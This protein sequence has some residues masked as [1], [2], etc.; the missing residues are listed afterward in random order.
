[1]TGKELWKRYSLEPAVTGV[2]GML[3]LE[4]RQF[5]Y[6]IARDEYRGEGEIMDVGAFLG[7]SAYALAAGLRDNPRSIDRQRRIH[8]CD[9]FTYGGYHTGYITGGSWKIGDDTLPIYRKHL[10]P[11]RDLVEPVKGDICAQRWDGRP[12]EIL[13]VDF[14]Q[15]SEHHDF[16]A[17]TFYPH[18]IPGNR[19]ILVH[20]GFIFTVGYWLHIFM[21]YYRDYFEL[22]DPHVGNS[23]AA[24]RVKQALPESALTQ[25]LTGRLRFTELLALLDTSIDRYPDQPWRGVLDCAR[26]RFFL[27][28][29]GPDAALREAKRVERG[30]RESALVEPHYAALMNDIRIWTAARSPASRTSGPRT[31][32]E[33]RIP[34]RREDST[35]R[36]SFTGER[37][38]PG[39][40]GAQIAHEH[41]HRYVFA[42]RFVAGRRV[43]DLG[44]GLGYGAEILGPHAREVVSLDHDPETLGYAR[45]GRTHALGPFVLGD[46]SRL[47]FRKASFDAVISFELIEHV[48]DQG[49]LV[50]EIRRVLSPSGVLLMST[51]DTLVYSEK[52]GERNPFHPKEMTTEELRALVAPH[53]DRL[54][55]YKQRAV[56]GSLM[57]PDGVVAENGAE[58]LVARLETDPPGLVLDPAEPDF[59]Y[60]VLVC[61]PATTLGQAPAASVLADAPPASGG[62]KDGTGPQRLARAQYREVWEALSATEEMAKLNVLGCSVEDE[63]GRTAHLTKQI[64]LET[65]GVRP[66]DTILEIGAGV[67]RVGRVLAPICTEWIGADVS[68]NMLGHITRRIGHLGNI[69]TVQLSGYDLSP[70]ASESVDLVYCTVVFMHLSEWER[71]R[72]IAE[73]M[74]VLRPGGRMLV[75]CFNLLSEE[76]WMVF[77]RMTGYP[78]AERPPQISATSTPQEIETYF[79]RA[80]FVDVRQRTRDIWLITYGRKP[81]PATA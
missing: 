24:W 5:L 4:E 10:E 12:I 46:A 32:R 79:T 56:S 9:F 62:P 71:F 2:P 58:L 27:H 76:G 34:L 60:N 75:D 44:C 81:V 23:T 25:P 16:V 26:A 6:H 78:P 42:R 65:V 54:V 21:E 36:P 77:H 14:T 43:L 28:T 33:T 11:F 37:F 49:T 38:V 1:M 52:L 73:G 18:L 70:I 30:M 20:Q 69:R 68:A 57:V 80:G 17:R 13:F 53:F 51:P 35:E 47:P 15:T 3:A 8:S 40:G 45:A 22:I 48:I 67:G 50:A 31:S 41:L 74:R 39:L 59:V 72:Y 29:L 61:G 66:E 64:L 63:F 55:V 7:A 19:S